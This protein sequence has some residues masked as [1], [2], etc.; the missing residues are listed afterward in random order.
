LFLEILVAPWRKRLAYQVVA[1]HGIA[2]FVSFAAPMQLFLFEL[3]DDQPTGATLAASLMVVGF[4]GTIWVG[5]RLLAVTPGRLQKGR[6]R[7][8]M[9][10]G[11][12]ALVGNGDGIQA[13]ARWIDPG[14]KNPFASR[15]TKQTLT[16]LESME[17]MHWAALAASAGPACAMFLFDREWL[18][19]AYVAA[20]LVYNVAPTVMIRDTRGRLLRVLHRPIGAGRP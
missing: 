2:M 12:R 9:L 3:F 19:A 5:G 6:V 7:R 13:V 1:W 8:A 20:N 15:S 10:R 17:L 14:W 18:G 11:F 16:W 4:A